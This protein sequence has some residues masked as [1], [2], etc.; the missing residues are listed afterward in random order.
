MALV[1]CLTLN[2][3]FQKLSVQKKIF[4]QRMLGDI[5]KDDSPC[6]DYC[7]RLRHRGPNAF[8]QFIGILI[9]TK[10]NDIAD[11]LWDTT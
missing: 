2:N 5:M 8:A 9:E 11:L 7:M 3:N 1:K 6:S 4:S 10:Q